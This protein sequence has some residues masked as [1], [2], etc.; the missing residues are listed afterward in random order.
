VG[1]CIDLT[2]GPDTGPAVRLRL[3][4]TEPRFETRMASCDINGARSVTRTG[5]SPGFFTF[6]C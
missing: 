3:L 1:D 4:A 2:S 6:S 5:F